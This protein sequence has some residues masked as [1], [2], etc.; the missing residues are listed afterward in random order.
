MLSHLQVGRINGMEMKLRRDLRM[1]E[2]FDRRVYVTG[3]D[4]FRIRD[5]PETLSLGSCINDADIK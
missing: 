3:G 5:L 1:P 2:T 4:F